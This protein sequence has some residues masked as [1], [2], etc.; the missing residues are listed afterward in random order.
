[1]KIENP[2]K[3]E[4]K[5]IGFLEGRPERENIINGNDITN[6]KIYLDFSVFMCYN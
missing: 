6:L 4:D 2:R 3:V 1:M 5:K